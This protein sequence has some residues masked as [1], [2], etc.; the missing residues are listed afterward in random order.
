MSCLL[1][2]QVAIPALATRYLG[3]VPG[4]TEAALCLPINMLARVAY[5]Y[6]D[7]AAEEEQQ[8]ID[9][10]LDQSW[11]SLG[12]SYNPF[13]ADPV[14]SGEISDPQVSTVRFL[15]VWASIGARHPL[16]Y[17]EALCAQ[18]SGLASFTC[19]S[20]VAQPVDALYPSEPNLAHPIF[21]NSLKGSYLESAWPSTPYT[22]TQLFCRNL[23]YALAGVPVVSLPFYLTTW[24]TLVPSA[25]LFCAI[26]TSGHG[27]SGLERRRALVGLSPYLLTV[28]LLFAN[29]V[30]ISPA[31]GQP[32]PTRYVFR[33]V[34]LVPVALAAVALTSPTSKT[35]SS[36]SSS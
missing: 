28:M 17:F 20:T 36:P 29:S 22:A 21:A 11:E 24:V 4:D 23:F 9:A 15:G 19:A 8:V 33:V 2:G 25:L 16:V 3:V 12:A 35:A 6:P 10:Y 5:L 27:S 31:A 14:S 13:S 1:L 30:T 32:S 26:R 7:D 18:E 34:A